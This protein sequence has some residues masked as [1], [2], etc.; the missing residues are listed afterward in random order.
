MEY[1]EAN[2]KDDLDRWARAHGCRV[3]VGDETWESIT[4]A[5]TAPAPDGTC[6][7]CR[8]RMRLP[9]SLALRRRE[10][11]FIVDLCHKVDGAECH[12]VRP[13]IAGLSTAS[14]TEAKRQAVVVASATVQIQRYQVCGANAEN[15]TTHSV[16]AATSWKG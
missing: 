10:R 15:L 14:E 11:T 3:R 12:H 5:A 4:Y 8:Y 7:Q 6:E 16:R 1:R 13:V 9:L 2:S